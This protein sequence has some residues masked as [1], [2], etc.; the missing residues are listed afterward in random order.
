MRRFGNI[1]GKC[2]KLGTVLAIVFA[3]CGVSAWAQADH[4]L[5]KP[6]VLSARRLPAVESGAAAAPTTAVPTRSA[7][8]AEAYFVDL[9]DGA[10]VPPKVVIHFGLKN[11]IVAHAG[12]DLENSGHHHLLIDTELPPLDQPIPSDFDHLHF[13]AGQ[14]EAV[15]SLKPGRHTLQLLLGDKD[16]LPHSPPVISR[17][18]TVR[19]VESKPNRK[20]H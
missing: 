8:G 3:G 10:I 2:V 14:T 16:H 18:I 13:G 9:K 20:S 1:E 4:A 17:R 7:L 6:Q 15:I 19:V 12:T 5:H 11:M